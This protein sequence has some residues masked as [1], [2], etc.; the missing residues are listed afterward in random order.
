MHEKLD[1]VSGLRKLAEAEGAN[2]ASLQLPDLDEVHASTYQSYNFGSQVQQ[3]GEVRTSAN[4][5]LSGK[6]PLDMVH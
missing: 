3:L 6:P 1:T 2:M 5:A 4:D